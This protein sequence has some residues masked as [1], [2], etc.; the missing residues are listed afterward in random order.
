MDLPNLEELEDA[1]RLI[2]PVLP[3]TPAY[4]WPLLSQR[5]GCEVWVKHENH[6][7]VGAFKVRGGLVYMDWLKRTQPDVTGVV[8]AT[9]GN[10]GQSLAFAGSRVGIRP[11]IVVPEGNSKEKN[12]AM[13]ALG[14][15]LIVHGQD[16]QDAVEHLAVLE[17]ERGLTRV[18]SFHSLL[19]RGVGTYSLEF[20]R[21]APP[22]DV[23]YVPIGLGS[24]ICGMI[25]AR[26]ALGLTTEIVGVVSTEAPAYALSFD[27][28]HPVSTNA[29]A[30]RIADGMACR[31]PVPE[32]VELINAHVDRIVQVSD[33][34]V[35]AAMRALF[36]DTHNVAEGAGAAGFAAIMQEREALAGKRAGMVLCGGNVDADVFARVLAA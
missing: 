12:A 30:T 26:Q 32:A 35:E 14:A 20:L 27:A 24:G 28:G 11:V 21:T 33:E 18:P 2:A 10:H 6:T 8:S 34:E 5:A 9:R 36:T 22:L 17:A 13:Q 16:F 29:A 19:V 3:A 1:G 31:T 15:E 7:P 25:A 23:V 4:T